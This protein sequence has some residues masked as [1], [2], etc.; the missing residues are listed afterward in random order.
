MKIYLVV[1]QI[2]PWA[3]ATSTRINPFGY[4]SGSM[5]MVPWSIM[6]LHLPNLGM[7]IVENLVKVVPTSWPSQCHHRKDRLV[8]GWKWWS[9][10]SRCHSLWWP[11]VKEHNPEL[12]F[13]SLTFTI[14]LS[15]LR[16]LVSKYLILE[17]T[18]LMVVLLKYTTPLNWKVYI[19]LY[20]IPISILLVL[21]LF[22][23]RI[24][25]LDE[26]SDCYV[27]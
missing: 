17:I 16:S 20:E 6:V 8:A 9:T 3:E 24:A 12:S 25:A 14:I 27:N 23:V 19:N 18:G 4:S 26:H 7:D 13:V 11:W 21:R 10:S 5:M 22:P 1:P 2:S 15:V